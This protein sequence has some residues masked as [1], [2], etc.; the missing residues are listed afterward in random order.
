VRLLLKPDLYA[1]TAAPGGDWQ[2]LWFIEVD[3]DTESTATIQTKAAAYEAY[4]RSGVEQQRLGAFPLVLWVTPDQ[5]RAETILRGICQD[6]RCDQRVHRATP[7][8]QLI[9]AVASQPDSQA[10]ARE[11]SHL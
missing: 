5:A 1:V 11:G 7:L 10:K 3:L 6:P 4:R 9:Q 8:H 2:D